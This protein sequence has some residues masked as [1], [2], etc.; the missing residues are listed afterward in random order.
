MGKT[1]LAL[2][3]RARGAQTKRY[4]TVNAKRVKTGAYGANVEKSRFALVQIRRADDTTE[5]ESDAVGT[6]NLLRLTKPGAH[7]TIAQGLNGLSQVAV[8]DM[9]LDGT[10]DVLAG[11]YSGYTIEWFANA[12]AGGPG[13]VSIVDDAAVFNRHVGPADLDQD[14]IG[15]GSV[16]KSLRLHF[17]T[18]FPSQFAGD[19]SILDSP[20]DGQTWETLQMTSSCRNDVEV[21]DLDGDGDPDIAIAADCSSVL[22]R[23]QINWTTNPQT[24]LPWVGLSKR[25]GLSKK[26]VDGTLQSAVSLDS[27]DIELSFDKPHIATMDKASQVEL[28]DLNGDTRADV[29]AGGNN[30]LGWH[31]DTIGNGSVWAETVITT[32]LDEPWRILAADLD[33]DG[34]IDVI[35]GRADDTVGWY[36]NQVDP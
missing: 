8:G 30:P 18:E 35:I 7:A 26:Q 15:T 29:I 16:G 2:G 19:G 5:V 28:A 23:W 17:N 11:T 20:G 22:H 12:P 25:V 1:P 24:Q 33:L 32:A 10:R 3:T 6:F 27:A 9:D 13:P 34:D 14:V 4:I 21:T 36:I 31:P